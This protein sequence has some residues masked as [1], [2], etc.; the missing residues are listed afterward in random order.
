MWGG[1]CATLG[2]T[3]PKDAEKNGEEGSETPRHV[4][5]CPRQDG[6]KVMGHL[7]RPNSLWTPRGSPESSCPHPNLSLGQPGGQ[8][9]CC[10]DNPWS[11]EGAVQCRVCGC[12]IVPYKHQGRWG[13]TCSAGAPSAGHGRVGNR[14][15]TAEEEFRLPGAAVHAPPG[16]FSP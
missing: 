8:F 10:T 1:C 12:L 4:R 11:G 5:S 3:T 9:W 13:G 2:C 15:N 14:R 6:D 7:Q 16:C